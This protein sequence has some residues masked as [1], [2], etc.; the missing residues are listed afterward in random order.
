MR[1]EA[2]VDLKGVAKK[3][4]GRKQ[5]LQAVS[6]GRGF[7]EDDGVASGSRVKKVVITL[8]VLLTV[9]LSAVMIRGTAQ[10]AFA[11]EHVKIKGAFHNEQA[12]QIQTALAPYLNGDL[13]TV[14]LAAA[15]DALLRLGWL[16]QATLRRQWPNEV[17]VSV[18]EHVPVAYWN[19]GLLLSDQ[20][21]AFAQAY[22]LESDDLPQLLGP[23]GREQ[24][25]LN[26]YRALQQL[27][28]TQSM[29]VQ[30]LKLDQRNTWTLQA[31]NEILFRLGS[32][33]I[34]DRLQR[35]LQVLSS[36]AGLE[37][38]NIKGVDL[39]HSNG[40]AISWKSQQPS[41]QGKRST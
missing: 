33:D 35:F 32:K 38:K 39:R 41:S 24:D 14:D 7:V 19:Q 28:Q 12:H 26:K 6:G 34:E 8:L 2:L 40:F 5:R 9:G 22:A 11:I 36:E 10:S 37:L 27:L 1:A 20:G 29:H 23:T 18:S 21:Q 25:V 31:N 30:Q 16:N 3:Q 4:Q 15:R 13:L 17:M